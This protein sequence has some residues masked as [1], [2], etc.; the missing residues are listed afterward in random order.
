MQHV[1]YR[2][3]AG[4]SALGDAP[5]RAVVDGTDAHVVTCPNSGGVMLVISMRQTMD[6]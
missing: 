1:A 6:V 3:G 5:R 2:V 4:V